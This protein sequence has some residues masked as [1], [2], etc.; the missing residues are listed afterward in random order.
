MGHGRVP[1]KVR[2]GHIGNGCRRWGPCIELTV[3]PEIDSHPEFLR[4]IERGLSDPCLLLEPLR[5]RAEAPAGRLDDFAN[6]FQCDQPREK[7]VHR[8]VE[9]QV[10]AHPMQIKPDIMRIRTYRIPAD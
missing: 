10:V 2:F 6:F 3:G 5:A 8:F 4:E 7:R 1:G 9:L